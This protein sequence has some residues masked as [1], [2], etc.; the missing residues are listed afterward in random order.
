[1][2]TPHKATIIGGVRSAP[3]GEATS[4]LSNVVS[5]SGNGG[6]P[7]GRNVVIAPHNRG[8]FASSL[9]LMPAAGPSP[10]GA[11]IGRLPPPGYPDHPQ[12]Y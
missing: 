9:I 2:I 7:A 4:A 5:P 3:R 6:G 8:V 1:M 11:S 10:I 12:W